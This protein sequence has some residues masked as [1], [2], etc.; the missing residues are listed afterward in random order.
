M[1]VSVCMRESVFVHERESTKKCVRERECV[2]V[3]K[4]IE[5]MFA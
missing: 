4:E 2:C 1:H 3:W 5:C